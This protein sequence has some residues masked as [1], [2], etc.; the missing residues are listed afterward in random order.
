MHIQD[1][2]AAMVPGAGPY[3]Q[4]HKKRGKYRERRAVEKQVTVIWKLEESIYGQQQPRDNCN[5]NNVEDD[6][7]IAK[8][9]EAMT[10]TLICRATKEGNSDYHGKQLPAQAAF[11]ESGVIDFHFATRQCRQDRLYRSPAP[12]SL[13][14]ECNRAAMG[15]RVDILGRT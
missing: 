12:W 10:S 13:R 2:W 3:E 1:L 15:F 11:G 8:H 9:H 5:R 7:R 6:R 14:A 4:E